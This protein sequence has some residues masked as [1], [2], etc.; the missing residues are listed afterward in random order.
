MTL[1]E[2]RD[3]VAVCSFGLPSPYTFHVREAHGGIMLSATYIDPDV[4]SKKPEI[5]YTRQWRL[6]PDMTKSEV[7]QT[8]FKCCVTSAEHRTREAFLYRGRRVFGPH[9]NVDDLWAACTQTDHREGA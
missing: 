6:S 7:V 3:V 1:D 9:F 8:V 2:M 5:Q 4:F